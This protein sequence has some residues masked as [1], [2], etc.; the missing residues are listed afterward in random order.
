MQILVRCAQAWGLDPHV[1]S[2][3]SVEQRFDVNIAAALQASQ[4]PDAERVRK[5][6]APSHVALAQ[7]I[8]EG[9]VEFDVIYIDGCHEPAAVLRD[10]CQA[11]E[12]LKPEGI[13][14][15]DDYAWHLVTRQP[16]RTCPKAAIDV[17]LNVYG[18]QL[19]VLELDYQCI[20]QKLAREQP[21]HSACKQTP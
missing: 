6:K 12:L 1:H 13:L 21:L 15:F 17:F 14:I 9:T 5:L 11:W 16:D 20:V 7:L 2:G 10:A 19:I 18:P 4:H 3:S 8:V